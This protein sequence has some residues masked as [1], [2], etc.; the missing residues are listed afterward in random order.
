MVC[1]TAATLLFAF[2]APSPLP[3][4]RFFGSGLIAYLFALS[5]SKLLWSCNLLR[6]E[7]F[8]SLPVRLSAFHRVSPSDTNHFTSD[9]QPLQTRFLNFGLR[10]AFFPLHI[11]FLH[12]FGFFFLDY[13]FHFIHYLLAQ[14]CFS[15]P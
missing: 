5:Y 13:I 8:S 3:L 7:V 12:M 10:S 1:S 15:L 4:C 2:S 11:F 14:D 6:T 9:S